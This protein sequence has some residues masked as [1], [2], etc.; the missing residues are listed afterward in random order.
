MECKLG[1]KEY[2]SSHMS[3]TG[4]TTELYEKIHGEGGLVETLEKDEKNGSTAPFRTRFRG[5]HITVKTELGN[6]SIILEII[7]DGYSLA[8]F[9]SRDYGFVRK[10]CSGCRYALQ[11]C[12]VGA[13][14]QVQEIVDSRQ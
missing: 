13:E 1:F 12:K 11:E 4:A 9:A 14:K 2:Q 5:P 6:Q 8:E 7:C 3:I 10:N